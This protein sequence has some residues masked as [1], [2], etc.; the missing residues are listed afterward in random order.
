MTTEANH[1]HV[2]GV[3]PGCSGDELK[4]AYRK[5]CLQHHP[6]KGG[7]AEVFKNVT[8]A[9]ETLSDEGKRAQYD[10][11]LRQQTTK[12]GFHRGTSNCSAAT[13]SNAPQQSRGRSG[14]FQQQSQEKPK[15]RVAPANLEEMS[16]RDLKHLLES[17]KVKHDDC[18]ERSELLQRVRDNCRS[19]A[20]AAGGGG[21]GGG[22]PWDP[23][24]YAA[25][26]N[27]NGGDDGPATRIKI[28]SMGPTNTGKSCLIK[29]F[30]EGR[31]VPR[32]ISTIGVD[33]GVKVI[34]I[35]KQRVKVNFFDLSGHEEFKDI[36]VDFYENAQG[37][38]LCFDVSSADSFRK[39]QSNWIWEA[40][41]Y[42][43]DFS[44]SVGVLCGN[45]VDCSAGRQVSFHEANEYARENGFLYYE[46]S[47]S[48]GE[49]VVQA[50]Q[51]CFEKI[52]G[53]LRR[54]KFDLGL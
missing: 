18:F 24:K 25:M 7:D 39:L 49:N 48:T 28:I 41:S 32:Y 23:S 21:G 36:R 16:A 6:D 42:G 10:L 9:W 26:T 38:L 33:Y 30:C 4:K 3:S 43:L 12:S 17:W 15:T 53:R 50:F 54:E 14:S 22:A 31:F 47:A 52:V 34:N 1:Y 11:T 20:G 2:L 5:A 35:M 46:L 19:T 29:R 44:N 27:L 37:V 13:S 8:I 40:R 45:K 51:F